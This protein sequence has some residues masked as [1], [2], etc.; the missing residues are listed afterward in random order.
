MNRT[1]VWAHRDLP[2]LAEMP[3][4]KIS[5]GTRVIGL[6]L[7]NSIYRIDASGNSACRSA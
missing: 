6:V 2:A 4:E 1:I 3:D 5:I 7:R